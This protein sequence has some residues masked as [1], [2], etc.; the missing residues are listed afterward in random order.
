MF[1]EIIEES[2][3]A[4]KLGG[5]STDLKDKNDL[6]SLVVINFPS[7]VNFPYISSTNPNIVSASYNKLLPSYKS[8]KDFI[9][10]SRI[11]PRGM[12]MY[13]ILMCFIGDHITVRGGSST[14][15]LMVGSTPT[16]VKA[17][18]LKTKKG[19]LDEF[20]LGAKAK[21]SLDK[22]KKTN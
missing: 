10:L 6:R 11:V 17:V 3:L 12:G 19:V 15:D 4:A 16:E 14:F 21:A 13:E 8:N 1:K 7:L 5:L 2:V 18:T 9:N 22:V 20:R